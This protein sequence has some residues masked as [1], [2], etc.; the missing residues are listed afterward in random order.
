M[1]SLNSIHERKVF[2][3]WCSSN[4]GY[5]AATAFVTAA[6]IVSLIIFYDYDKLT[7]WIPYLKDKKIIDMYKVFHHNFIKNSLYP[8]RYRDLYLDT[9][10]TGMLEGHNRTT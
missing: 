1:N 7:L 10:A 5:R 6:Y 2:F 9:V 3:F 8:F 4:H